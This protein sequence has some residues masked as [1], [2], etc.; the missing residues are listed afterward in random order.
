MTRGAAARAW[1]ARSAAV[2]SAVA[3]VT[4]GSVAVVVAANKDD[5]APDPGAAAE[6]MFG[7]LARGDALGALEALPPTERRAIAPY[8]PRLVSELQRLGLLPALSLTGV[9]GGTGG[10]LR[11][12]G[13]TTS[14]EDWGQETARVRVTGGRLVGRMGPVELP[15]RTRGLVHDATG[16]DLPAPGEPVD[17][18]LAARRTSVLAVKEGGGWHLSLYQTIVD[19]V[20]D[21]TG[22]RPARPGAPAAI[23]SNTPEE[24]APDLWKAISDLDVGR[25]FSLFD[26]DEQR[27][28]YQAQPLF[29]PALRRD[30]GRWVEDEGFGFPP[31]TVE[32]SVE[33]TGP[34]RI[35][36]IT[37]FDAK[38]R[39]R[40]DTVRVQYNGT[41]ALWEHRATFGDPNAD[42][43]TFQHCDGD[44]TT[45]IDTSVTGSRTH[46]LTAWTG[47]G[48]AFPTF[49][50][51]ERNGRWFISP[52]RSVLQTLIEILEP[53][54]PAQAGLLLD[55]ATEVAHTFRPPPST[56]GG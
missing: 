4:L 46:Q 12:E 27:A 24:S 8:L 2:A 17:V 18:D 20:V 6:V 28:L 7:A 40:L 43:A 1:W 41:C 39:D 56:A 10:D 35:V 16:F 23:G 11:V 15:E 13:L 38:W 53:L 55:R 19:L 36:R 21:P 29:L 49:V 45:P 48:R 3:L 33:G 9:L 42:P 26:G 22:P 31:P 54:T 32:V 51:R 14:S 25:L 47:L 34:E 52:T 50:V 5:G 30:A 37:R 44:V